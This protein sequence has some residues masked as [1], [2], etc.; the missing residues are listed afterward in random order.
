MKDI[1]DSY[2]DFTKLRLPITLPLPPAT[3]TGGE[4]ELDWGKVPRLFMFLLIL[5]LDLFC[6][7]NLAKFYLVICV[8]VT[9][10]TVL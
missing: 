7:S 9:R 5:V 8:L 3:L 4:M 2:N 1:P 10:I 6:Y